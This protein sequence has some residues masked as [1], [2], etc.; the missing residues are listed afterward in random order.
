MPS[1]LCPL[2]VGRSTEVEELGAA[3][4]AVAEARRGSTLLLMGEAGVG[5]FRLAREA[6]DIARRRRFSVLWGRATP[7][8]SQVAFRPLAEALL[9]QF[10]DAGPPDSPELEPFRPIL[11]RVVPEWR[12]NSIERVDESIVL[13]AEA[14]LRVLRVLGRA[15][16]CLIVLED[17]HWADPDT[18][19]IVEYLADNLA[20][21]PVLCLGT[22]RP[23]E[24]GP[25]LDV[26]NNLIAR[27]V[28]SAVE[29]SP[30]A[31][32]DVSTMARSCL[33]LT[34][35]PGEFESILQECADGLPF[36]VEELLAGAAGAG[37]V[38]RADH[39]W[40]VE[41]GFEPSAPRTLTLPR[42]N[43][44]PLLAFER[45]L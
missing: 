18:L 10:R 35:L 32:S 9:S 45:P 12:E 41:S 23:E 7:S 37:V 22:L 29:V 26:A 3:V 40:K 43:T 28:A 4:A 27:R 13:L 30:L 11:A 2:L 8:A 25:G 6:L 34:S 39:G 36:L 1:L 31:A 16:G 19:A 44:A 24:A 14:V 38:V 21:E 42:L 33:G 20:S 5:K 17:L 15:H